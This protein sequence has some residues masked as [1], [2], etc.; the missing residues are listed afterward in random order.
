MRK[1]RYGRW[2]AIIVFVF[3]CL[4][5]IGYTKTSTKH[6]KVAVTTSLIGSIVK[7][8]GKD[9]VE[10]TTIVPG[11]MCPGHFDVKP[12]DIRALSDARLLLY[13]GF[14][15]WIKDLVNSVENRYLLKK[16]IETKGSWMVPKNHIQIVDE[17]TKIL[18]EVDSVNGFW[19][20]KNSNSF[21]QEID[22]VRLEI[23]KLSEQI[24]GTK[25]VCVEY[26][27]EFLKW[28]GLKIIATYGRPSEL[29]SRQIMGV[30]KKAR[31]HDVMLVVDNLQSGK[32]AG[33]QIAEEISATHITLTNFPLGDSYIDAL[34]ENVDEILKAIE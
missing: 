28:L 24:Q 19:Y 17:I 13:H 32:D 15:S 26:Q 5:S 34:K 11:G 21:K 4:F 33:K 18:C 9:K 29:T 27:E 10:V 6:P 16:V 23:E 25:V 2:S 30:I 1:F 3:Y 12:E 31:T 7:T 8:V 20:R 14:E 22:T